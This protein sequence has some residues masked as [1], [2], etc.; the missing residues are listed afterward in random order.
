MPVD[1]EKPY[2]YYVIVDYTDT[3]KYYYY[4]PNFKKNGQLK[5]RAKKYSGHINKYDEDEFYDHANRGIYKTKPCA[6]RD[7]YTNYLFSIYWRFEDGELVEQDSFI[8]GYY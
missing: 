4:R 1:P 5:K 6:S 7:H 8:Y 2:I 3:D